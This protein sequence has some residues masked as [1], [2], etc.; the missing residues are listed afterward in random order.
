MLLVTVMQRPIR[1]LDWEA[2]LLPSNEDLVWSCVCP[3][4]PNMVD[5]ESLVSLL[6]YFVSQLNIWRLSNLEKRIDFGFSPL[7]GFALVSDQKSRCLYC[8]CFSSI[9]LLHCLCLCSLYI[10]AYENMQ[11][12]K[13]ENCWKSLKMQLS[14]AANYSDLILT[15]RHLLDIQEKE[16]EDEDISSIFS[17]FPWLRTSGSLSC[18]IAQVSFWAYSGSKLNFWAAS[19]TVWQHILSSKSKFSGQHGQ[20]SRQILRGLILA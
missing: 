14:T 7:W 15:T 20:V 10:I 18:S 3:R 12:M 17:I 2:C 8:V 6:L 9:V 16:K 13:C 19:R 1:G 5:D 11:S 4:R